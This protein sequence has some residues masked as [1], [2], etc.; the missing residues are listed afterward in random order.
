MSPLPRSFSEPTWS[1]MV[2]ESCRLAVAKEMRQG[3]LA[4]IV[5][6][7]TSTEGRWVATIR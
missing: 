4:L 2:R 7:S 5:P 1:R 6:V 3:K